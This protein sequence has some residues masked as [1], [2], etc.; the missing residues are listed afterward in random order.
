MSKSRK[1]RTK[2][3]TSVKN[4]GYSATGAN[5]I[6]GSMASWLPDRNSPQ[7]DIDYNLSTLRGRSAE[8]A[9]GGSPLASGAIENAR[10]YV[11]GAGL[12]LAPSPK[13]RL[14]KM[15]PEEAD[16]WAFV[17]RE[18]FDLW[19]N[20]VFADILHKNNFYDMQDI[21]FNSYLVDGDSFAVIKQETPNAA[22]PFYLRLQLVEAARVCNPYS[23]GSTS[24]VY[25]YNQDNG[26]R[27]VSG[28]EIDKNGAV[29]A[30]HIANKYPNDRVSDGT[31]P[32]WA[33]VKAFGESTG[34]RNVLQISHETRP[35]QYRGIPY[36]A[37]VITTLKQVGRYTDAELT[38][39]IIKSFFTLFFT[40]TQAHDKAF[41]L[42]SLN[43][44]QGNDSETATAD[45]LRKIQFKLGPGTLNAL[46]PNWDV[47][48]IDASKN[49]S[50]FDPFTNQ[51]IKMI[52]SAIGQPAEV[53]T[54]AFNSSYSASRAALLQAWAGFKTYRTWFANDLCQPVYEMWLSEA[55]ARGY[56]KAPGFF[57]NPL[58]RAAYCSANWY[59]PVMGMID[60]VKEAQAGAERIKLGLST[61]EK[62]CAELSGTSFSDNVA[63][64]AIENKQLKEAGL[65]V[66]AEE[67][68]TD[69][70]ETKDE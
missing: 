30:Y 38:T 21:A 47:K 31:I 37:N 14:L 3:N 7:S 12:H 20:S 48:E 36:L 44:G 19:A 23:G 65:P 59:G 26:N 70:K 8:L 32:A 67:V 49:L 46:P 10:Q 68:K 28:V 6:V 16:E 51:L 2:K 57:E 33:R 18:A 66:Y 15:T 54:K 11:V 60:P 53:L 1:F 43:G 24:N 62:E 22:M 25:Q 56:I 64:L 4:S 9:M 17:T 27:I 45:E 42:D 40:Q 39:A 29:V 69:V 35:D 61:R 5:T 63:R 52:G 13:Y 58:V 50:T 34:N 41:P 55:V